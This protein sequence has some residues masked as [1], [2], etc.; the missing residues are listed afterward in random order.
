MSTTFKLSGASFD[1]HTWELEAT[2]LLRGAT[3]WVPLKCMAVLYPVSV[4]EPFKAGQVLLLGNGSS[5]GVLVESKDNAV[6]VELMSLASEGDWNVA[7]WL[8]AM[9]G[10]LGAEITGAEGEQLGVE[11]LRPEAFQARSQKTQRAE[12]SMSRGILKQ[13]G[14]DHLQF[15]VAH[16]ELKLSE[17]ELN[18]L[19]LEAVMDL[20]VNQCHRYGNAHVA[21]RMERQKPDGSRYLQAHYAGVATLVPADVE[22]MTFSGPDGYYTYDAI[23]LDRVKTVLGEFITPVARFLYFPRIPWD[24]RPNLLE[25]LTG[26]SVQEIRESLDAQLAES[27]LYL[28]VLAFIIAAQADGAVDQKETDAF[29]ACIQERAGDQNDQSTFANACRR[30]QQEMKQ[31]IAAI[32]GLNHPAEFQLGIGRLDLRLPRETATAYKQRLYELAEAVAQASGD[33]VPEKGPKSSE[34]VERVLAWMKAVLFP[35]AK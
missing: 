3:D 4:T 29:F 12:L 26:K 21:S 6:R 18:G 27:I 17:S 25:T 35:A 1:H 32:K 7:R 30:L 8:L 16:F 31:V 33:G 2:R 15:P 22:G 34:F 14:G 19:E 13:D 9:G 5:R 28:P 20:L 11:E 24:Q 10:K 23:P